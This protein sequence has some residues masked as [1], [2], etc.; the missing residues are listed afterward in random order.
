MEEL[1][2]ECGVAMVRLRKPLT[3]YQEKYG[4]WRYGLNKMYLLMEKQ[5]NR[6]QDGAGISCVKLTAPTGEEYMYRER[7]LGNTAITEIFGAVEKHIQTF[8][9][10]KQADPNFAQTHIP[11][12]AECY[13]GH[14]RYATQG[15]QE[16]HYVHPMLRRNNWRAKSLALCGNFTLTSVDKIFDEIT[17]VGQHPRSNSDT[18]IILEQLGHRL[19]R[20]VEHKFRESKKKGLEGMDITHDIESRIDMTTPLKE[21][22]PLWDGGYT[23]CGLTGS[24]EMFML[25]DPWGIRPAFYYYDDEIVVCAS[26]RAV[27]QTVLNVSAE[28][29]H[30]LDRGDTLTIDKTGAKIQVSNIL[31]KRENKACSFERIYFSRASDQDIYKERKKLGEQLV[32]DVLKAIDNDIEHSVF[33]F[34][35]NTAEVSY[36]GMIEGM[37]RHFNKYRAELIT[38]NPNMSKEEVFELLDKRVRSEKVVI[39]DIKLRTFI[40]EGASRTDLAQHVYDITYGTVEKGVD[41]LVVIDD[42]I[43]RG[44]TLKESIIS[45]LDRLNPKKIVVVSSAPQIRYPDHYGI[46]MSRMREFVAFLAAIDLLLERG[47]AYVIHDTYRAIIEH[48]HTPMIKERNFVK[49]IYQ[50]FT[51]EEINHKIVERLKPSSVKA[52][53]ELV[54]QSLEGLHTAIPEHP[55]DWYFSGDYPTPGGMEKTNLA[56][57]LYYEQD[58]RKI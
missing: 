16:I 44:T 41:N 25:R 53:V 31:P 20:E 18:H 14:L 33:S 27:I 51:I 46:D 52:E 56:Y 55:G 22:A 37:E 42:S 48:L 35:P 15:K 8:S 4:T 39:K 9:Q 32:P 50:P 19:D 45:I 3:Y 49:D 30:E 7:A 21:C 6:G 24:G 43:V 1:K 10:E 54:F 57:K 5:H 36:F 12:A 13:M 11:Y 40:S 17:S 38:N 23:M 28:Q 34:I 29:V 47:M 58:F 2:H 26:E